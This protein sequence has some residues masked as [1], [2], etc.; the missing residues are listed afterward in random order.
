MAIG[1]RSCEGVSEENNGLAL[2]YNI[3]VPRKLPEGCLSPKSVL[4]LNK[5]CQRDKRVERASEAG[6]AG[7]TRKIARMDVGLAH[8]W[9]EL[10]KSMDMI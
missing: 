1:G 2:D 9:F 7:S 5:K 4:L 10:G 6:C 3:Y 8:W